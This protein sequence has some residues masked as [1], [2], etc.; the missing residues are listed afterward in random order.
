VAF[1]A[2]ALAAL[3]SLGKSQLDGLAL[4]ELGD[5]WSVAVLGDPGFE[6][7]QVLFYEVRREGRAVLG[8]TSFGLWFPRGELDFQLV[9]ARGGNVVAVTEAESP[10]VVLVICDLQSG[11]HWP[12][13]CGQG[14]THDRATADPLLEAL[15]EAH[16]QTGYILNAGDA[17]SRVGLYY[18]GRFP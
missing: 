5:A 14:E 9:R 6:V 3:L 12:P 7:G 16:P 4:F 17:G 15:R 2:A 13:C 18:A 10:R 1:L 8:P 11:Q